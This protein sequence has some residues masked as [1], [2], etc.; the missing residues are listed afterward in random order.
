MANNT[1]QSN[2]TKMT[3]EE[4][5]KISA[6]KTRIELEKLQN[7]IK[8]TNA[9]EKNNYKS[10]SDIESVS[11]S[12]EDSLDMSEEVKPRKKK[13]HMSMEDRMYNDNQKLWKKNQE[14][15]IEL[16]RS[17]KQL[18]YLQ[19]EHNNKS[20][21]ITEMKKKV[22]DYQNIRSTLFYSKLNVFFCYFIILLFTLQFKFQIPVYE[23]ASD[24]T[25]E[26]SQKVITMI[27]E[28]LDTVD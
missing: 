21:E 10:P 6:E 12:S 19:Y 23:I 1:I 2:C 5:D 24:Y 26:F 20:I 11:S 9:F 3:T 27:R 22:L 7:E 18:R 8:K 14:L 28:K 4:V 17:S 15:K 25:K 13:V 16:E